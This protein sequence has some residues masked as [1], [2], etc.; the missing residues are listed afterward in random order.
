[1]TFIEAV[2]DLAQQYG[3]QIPEDEASPEDRARA[4]LPAA[5]LQVE[6]SARSGPSISPSWTC[7]AC[8]VAGLPVWC[9]GCSARVRPQRPQRVCGFAAAALTRRRAAWT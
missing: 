2:K 3:M 1:M 9:G 5:M 7:P 8:Q 6:A 4:A